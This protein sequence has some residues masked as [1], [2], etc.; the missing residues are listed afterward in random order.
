MKKINNYIDEQKKICK[1]YSL[2]EDLVDLDLLI[3]MGKNFNPQ[4][5][6]NGLRHPKTETLSGW[7][8]WSGEDFNP[9]DFDFFKPSHVYHLIPE[10]SFIIKYLGIPSG[11]RFLIAEQGNYV[12]IWKDDRLL[13]V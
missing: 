13:E 7:Y 6:I 8:I 2:K 1:K 9:D 12:D 4:L 5:I 11:N 3:A 10:T